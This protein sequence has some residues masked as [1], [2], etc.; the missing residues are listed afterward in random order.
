MLS[1]FLFYDS[2]ARQGQAPL[3]APQPVHFG[4][5]LWRKLRTHIGRDI[6]NVVLPATVNEPLSGL[7][8]IAEDLEYHSL[9]KRALSE[10]TST[11]RLAY[12]TAFVLSAYNSCLR[13]RKPFNPMVGETFE[14]I[15][16]DEHR[17]RFHAE[18]VES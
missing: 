13:T 15:S 7:Q 11:L 8:R 14:F 10:Q 5:S 3:P 4:F 1:L 6:T 18:Q 12:V 16:N 17:I 9:L 2:N